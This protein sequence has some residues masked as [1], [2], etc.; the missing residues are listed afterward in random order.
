[1]SK[2]LVLGTHFFDRLGVSLKVQEL[3]SRWDID[4]TIVD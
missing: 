2:M 3:A 1:M 4:L